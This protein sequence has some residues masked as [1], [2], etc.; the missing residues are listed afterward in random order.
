MLSN[1]RILLRVLAEIGIQFLLVANPFGLIPFARTP[2]LKPMVPQTLYDPHNDASKRSHITDL[3]LPPIKALSI[4]Q[5]RRVDYKV[6]MEDYLRRKEDAVCLEAASKALAIIPD[7][8]PS[9][10]MGANGSETSLSLVG[11]S[12]NDKRSVSLF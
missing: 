12:T 3:A 10:H 5:D 2:I 1:L 9:Q 8:E 6:W 11:H 4:Y 7:P